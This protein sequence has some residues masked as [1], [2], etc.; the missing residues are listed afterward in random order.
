MTFQFKKTPHDPASPEME[1]HPNRHDYR[2][3]E[4]I[5]GANIAPIPHPGKTPVFKSFAAGEK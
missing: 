5:S 1:K 4:R 3:H 2:A